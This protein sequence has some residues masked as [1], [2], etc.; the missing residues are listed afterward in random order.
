MKHGFLLARMYHMWH[1]LCQAIILRSLCVS[2]LQAISFPSRVRAERCVSLYRAAL[3]TN[4]VNP[5]S[6]ML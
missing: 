4:S 2:P 5:K 1:N 3:T 6:F